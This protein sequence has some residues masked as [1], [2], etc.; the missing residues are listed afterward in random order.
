MRRLSLIA[1]PLFALAAPLPAAAGEGSLGDAAATLSDPVAQDRMADTVAALVGALMQM[2]VG[3]LAEAVARID[4][5]SDA[6]YIPP[7][8]TLGEVTGSDPGYGE[9]LGDEVRAGTRIAGSMAAALAAYAPVL[10]DMARD[11]AAQWER[12]RASARR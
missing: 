10:K 11:M 6:A 4:P 8:A 1:L 2:P 5:E 7:D 12:E 9:R 3:P